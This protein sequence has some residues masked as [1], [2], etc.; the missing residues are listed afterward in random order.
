VLDI[1]LYSRQFTAFN[2]LIDTNW[3]SHSRS[4]SSNEKTPAWRIM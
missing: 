1:P 4:H 2:K 3:R